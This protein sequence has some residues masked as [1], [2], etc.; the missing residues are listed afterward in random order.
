MITGILKGTLGYDLYSPKEFSDIDI[1]K[2]LTA[3]LLSKSEPF[4][5]DPALCK[6]IIETGSVPALKQALKNVPSEA[7][8]AGGAIVCEYA[9]RERMQKVLMGACLNLVGCSS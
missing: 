7:I 8:A 2:K 4:V 6:E 9:F 3:S 5:N 1:L